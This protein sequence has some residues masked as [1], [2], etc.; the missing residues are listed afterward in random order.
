MDIL[1]KSR[2][3][4]QRGRKAT[5]REANRPGTTRQKTAHQVRGHK[6]AA[7]PAWVLDPKLPVQADAVRI[8]DNIVERASREMTRNLV[9]S[10]SQVIP[11]LL[12]RE[13]DASGPGP[14]S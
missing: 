2:K 13:W 9:E 4:L 12:S 11:P 5:E 6:V 10:F 1:G 8:F 7:L 14:P 3:T